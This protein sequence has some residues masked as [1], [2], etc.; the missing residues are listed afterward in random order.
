MGQKDLAEEQ[1]LLA[2]ELDPEN[3]DIR[4]FGEEVR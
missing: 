1:Y 2:L 4:R 3:R